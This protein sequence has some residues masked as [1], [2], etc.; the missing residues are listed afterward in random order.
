MHVQFGFL[1]LYRKMFKKKSARRKQSKGLTLIELMIVIA[2]LALLFIL[3]ALLMRTQMSRTRDAQRKADLER[4]KIAFEDYYNDNGCYPTQ[5]DYYSWRCNSSDFNPYLDIFPCDPITN[6]HYTY[7]PDAV[8]CQ[9][10]A[11]LTT[12]EQTSDPS[13]GRAGC[14][15][16]G[17]GEFAD[18]YGVS[19]GFPLG[20]FIGSGSQP[21][22][23]AC[24]D[25][26]CNFYND[27]GAAGC[28]QVSTEVNCGGCAVGASW[29]NY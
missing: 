26:I 19:F 24:F 16:L 4:L 5:E 28:T 1:E 12:L 15:A 13:I 3:I 22:A 18:N 2:I 8:G 20:N 6:L 21:P 27:P 23:H 14:T 10:Y 7:V 11:I 17:C 9:G 29:C 25:G